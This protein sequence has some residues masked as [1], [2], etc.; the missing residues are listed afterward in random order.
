MKAPKEKIEKKYPEDIMQALKALEIKIGNQIRLYD[1][2]SVIEGVLMP[3]IGMGDRRVLIIKRADGYNTGVRYSNDLE[4][5]KIG[6][7]VKLE[8]FP[9]IA[10]KTNKKLTSMSIIA[11]GGTISSRVDYKTGAVHMLLKPEEFLF[12]MPEIAE[13]VNIRSFLMPFQLASE[14]MALPDIQKIARLAAK[15]LNSGVNGVCVT[16]GTDTLHYT[17]AALSF[18]LAN[19]P[20]PVALVGAQ[21][22]PDRGS[23]DGVLNMACAAHYCASDIA[24]VAVV[25]H[26]T[27]EDT[28]AF[29]LR[30]TKVRKM[31]TSRRD[32]FRPIN[33]QPLAKIWPDGNIEEISSRLGRR[34]DGEVQLRE[35]VEPKVTFLKVFP[36]SNP[37]LLE[38]CIDKGYKGVV[39]EASGLGHVPTQTTLGM[40]SWFPAIKR[41]I[42]E[43]LLIAFAPQ[44]LYG[45]LQPYVY[46]NARIMKELGVVYLEDLLPETAYIKL[47]WVL[48]Q[49]KD[50]NEAKKMLLKNIAGEFGTPGIWETFLY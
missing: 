1:N 23:N 38:F 13:I 26:G 36:G 32:T 45:R 47:A 24:E 8:S 42:E 15:E 3:R 4:I 39:V 14:D 49:T 50:T 48:G 19:L 30:G 22:S 40:N 28:F 25:M 44:C 20:A 18:M 35:A 6:E 21:R 2:D 12:T 9:E 7:G 41:A 27:P 37:E 46:S 5:K 10:F 17:A 43:D 31:H 33:A 34:K 11:T 29:V 16:H